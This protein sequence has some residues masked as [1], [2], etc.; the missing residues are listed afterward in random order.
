M[1]DSKDAAK[2]AALK[3]EVAQLEKEK[4]ELD[5]RLEKD[6]KSVTADMTAEEKHLLEIAKPK[7]LKAPSAAAPSQPPNVQQDLLKAAMQARNDAL[8]GRSKQPATPT[9]Q[10]QA[11]D[12]SAELKKAINLEEKQIAYLEGYIRI[13][14]RIAGISAQKETKVTELPPN[15]PAAV[16]QASES[17]DEMGSVLIPPPPPAP[18][19]PPPPPPSFVPP[20]PP[21]V[22]PPSFSAGTVKRPESSQP[23]KNGSNVV[24]GKN[25]LL[26][27]IQG[28]Q[29]GNLRRID[30]GQDNLK[31]EEQPAKS[32]IIADI[33]QAIQLPASLGNAP[34][35]K[36]GEED[37]WE[38]EQPAQ[39]KQQSESTQI[40]DVRQPA[41]EEDRKAAEQRQAEEAR[42]REEQEAKAKA[43]RE[44]LEREKREAEATKQRQEQEEAR[45]AEELRKAEEA[46]QKQEQE[47]K[48]REE[49]EAK[50]K[51][52]RAK[53]E[54]DAK[55]REAEEARKKAEAEQKKEQEAREKAEREEAELAR[56]EA[57]DKKREADQREKAEQERLARERQ[58]QAG[59]AQQRADEEARKAAAAAKQGEQTVQPQQ[60]EREIP[61]PVPQQ[62][63]AQP[64]EPER[65][66]SRERRP[67][68]TRAFDA[69]KTSASPS[70]EPATS[71]APENNAVLSDLLG[72]LLGREDIQKQY[73]GKKQSFVKRWFIRTKSERKE[74][75]AAFQK[76][77]DEANQSLAQ[78]SSSPENVAVDLHK[79]LNPLLEQVGNE[80]RATGSPSRLQSIL[81]DYVS[82]LE[83][84]F[85]DNPEMKNKVTG[86]KRR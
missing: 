50:T 46:K 24:G 42:K 36:P 16:S 23:I 82:Q 41:K 54:A 80:K 64:Q 29:Q 84:A 76:A 53:Q 63:K 15:E 59:E 70:P 58:K 73:E 1:A 7:V 37:G 9:V 83:T 12:P 14:E 67:S 17:S 57:E 79:K 75:I 66:S 4:Q 48:K 51:V 3:S 43:E 32:G 49:Q 21:F 55:K 56:K 69:T 13:A 8:K 72:T 65:R 25:A 28:F 30:Q 20:P 38:E 44:K 78:G 27:Q 39:L 18:V 77:V 2:L 81:Q 62:E 33:M 71:P 85:P 61:V 22:P 31:S 52:E 11:V 40:A 68:I 47:A 60:P 86:L 10:T 35:S 45:K 6:G 5:A 74:Q 26:E 34:G 19:P